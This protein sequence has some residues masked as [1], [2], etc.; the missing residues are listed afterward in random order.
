MSAQAPKLVDL[1]VCDEVRRED[2][3]KLLVIGMYLGSILV[4]Q[5]PFRM[6]KLSFFFKWKT[7][8]S[9]P[10]GEFRL[11]NPSKDVV[12]GFG[13]KTDR[14]PDSV[15]ALFY[16]TFTLENIQL[17]EVGTYTLSY[18]PPGGKRFRPISSFEVGQKEGS[19]Q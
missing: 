7:N 18:K 2:N 1:I 15:G 17:T 5:V 3:G 13:M 9:L 14:T 10:S 11:A 6:P 8:G 16:M 12:G 19:S 4:P